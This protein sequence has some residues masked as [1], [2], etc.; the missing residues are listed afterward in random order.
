[1]A[2]QMRQQVLANANPISKREIPPRQK[3]SALLP[4]AAWLPR[5]QGDILPDC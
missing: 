2:W 4:S 3:F 1:M 5:C